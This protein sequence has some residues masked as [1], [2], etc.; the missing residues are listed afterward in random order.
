MAALA[1]YED[2]QQWPWA[3]PFELSD[4]KNI[5]PASKLSSELSRMPLC[6]VP[7]LADLK[8]FHKH[9]QQTTDPEKP[10]PSDVSK[11]LMKL[12]LPLQAAD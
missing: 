10:L 4:N 11:D 9:E 1:F 6:K 2:I 8:A 12:N 5:L 3:K 7:A